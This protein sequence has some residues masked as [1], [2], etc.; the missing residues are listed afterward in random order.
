LPRIA[1]MSAADG[2][3]VE[4]LAASLSHASPHANTGIQE[5]L[6]RRRPATQGEDARGPAPVPVDLGKSHEPI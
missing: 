1:D 6:N 5:F 4:S 3:F 2:L